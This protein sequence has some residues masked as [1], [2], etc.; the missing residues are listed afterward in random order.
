MGQPKLLLDIHGRTVIRRLID[1]FHAGGVATIYVLVRQSDTSLQAELADTGARVVLTPD[2]PDMRASVAVLLGAV[3]LEHCPTPADGWLLAPADHPLLQPAV[4]AELLAARRPGQSEILVPS[5]NGR[6]GH[7][8]CFSWD[9][10]ARVASLPDGVGV[11][12]LLK[13]FA[14]H[15]R[16]VPVA[17]PD[18]LTDLDT[19]ADLERLR[20]RFPWKPDASGRG[21]V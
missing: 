19:P 16:H 7:P 13:D 18:I 15:T 4:I 21:P 12:Q 10:A 20:D 5:H 11:N 17:T 3:R 8:T 9:F 14:A 2:T 1:A 6:R